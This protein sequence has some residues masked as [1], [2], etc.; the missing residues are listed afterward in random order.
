MR[1]TLDGLTGKQ[2]ELARE[3]IP[4]ITNVGLLVNPT[5]PSN[6]PQRS[7]AENGAR[8]LGLGLVPF[9]VDMPDKLDTALQAL[10]RER[11]DFVV[12]VAFAVVRF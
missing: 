10:A 12:S 5:D 3:V 8:A 2:F 6:P 11:V 1:F 7:D 4:R 9:D